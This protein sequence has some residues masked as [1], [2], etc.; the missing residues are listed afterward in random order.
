MT[1]PIVTPI[2]TTTQSQHSARRVA[3]SA[4]GVRLS[5]QAARDWLVDQHPD[6]PDLV[7]NPFLVNLVLDAMAFGAHLE[8][9]PMPE[10]P[11]PLVPQP[12]EHDGIDWRCPACQIDRW[13]LQRKADHRY[14]EMTEAERRC[15]S[16]QCGR[17][18]AWARQAEGAV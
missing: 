2:P 3:A 9:G 4:L 15:W 12:A 18:E 8:R 11:A 1:T 16:A 13:K 14:D 10:A 6:R 7:A 5:R 17:R